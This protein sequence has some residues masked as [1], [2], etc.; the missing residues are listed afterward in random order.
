MPDYEQH[1]RA[2]GYTG[3]VSSRIQVQQKL[4]QYQQVLHFICNKIRAGTVEQIRAASSRVPKVR[5]PCLGTLLYPHSVCNV[6]HWFSSKE[7]ARARAP[8]TTSLFLIHS[9]CC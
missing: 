9:V 2:A 1:M 6:Q 7:I 4:L 3:R 5:L 8:R